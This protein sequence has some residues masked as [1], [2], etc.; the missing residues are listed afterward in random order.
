MGPLQRNP[1]TSAKYERRQH[2]IEQPVQGIEEHPVPVR[3][4]SLQTIL[5]IRVESGEQGRYQ[6]RGEDEKPERQRTAC[7]GRHLGRITPRCWCCPAKPLDLPLAADSLP[8]AAFIRSVRS[9]LAT[10]VAWAISVS[11]LE[12]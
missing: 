7:G 3:R 9:A 1:A 10:I 11:L 12:P 2:G 5:N 6:P 8:P 4:A